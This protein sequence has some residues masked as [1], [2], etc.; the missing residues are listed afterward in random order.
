LSVA[1]AG[2]VELGISFICQGGGLRNEP[3]RYQ[4]QSNNFRHLARETN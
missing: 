2:T 3:V 1:A 4:A